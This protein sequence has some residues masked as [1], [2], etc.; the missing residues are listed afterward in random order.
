MSE[1]EKKV[2]Q[3][4]NEAVVLEAVTFVRAVSEHFNGEARL[5]STGDGRYIVASSVQGGIDLFGRSL[6]ETMV[7]EADK[8]GSVIDW[9][10]LGVAYPAGEWGAA[11][12]N[13]GFEVAG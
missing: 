10:E 8:R 6:N 13:A 12:A 7:F 11:L 5:Y 3:L 2:Y 1:I 9:G 4:E